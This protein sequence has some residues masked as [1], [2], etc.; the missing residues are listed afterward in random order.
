LANHL[1]AFFAQYPAFVYDQKSS[2][3]EEF[4]RL[5]DFFDWDRD[6]PER[7]EAYAS[8][9]I[10]LVQQF[11]SLYGTE[12]DDIES[13]RGL[14]LALDI[15][16]LPDDLREAKKVFTELAFCGHFRY[17]RM[18]LILRIDVRGQIREPCRPGRHAQYRPLRFPVRHSGG[19]QGLYT[20]NGKILP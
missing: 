17:G 1:D 9:K 15:V 5:C 6:D 8:F 10:A 16:P 14:S 20:S 7:E 11:N 12:V 2:S 4:Y 19:T 13:W 18:A 3:S